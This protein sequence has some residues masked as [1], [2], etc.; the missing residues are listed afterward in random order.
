M[1]SPI[2]A[3]PQKSLQKNDFH[4]K[5]TKEASGIHRQW[6]MDPL[7]SPD[8]I[9]ARQFILSF[10]ES[11]S[12]EQRAT[13]IKDQ[14]VV[15][16]VTYVCAGAHRLSKKT[17]TPWEELRAEEAEAAEDKDE[18]EEEH[19]AIVKAGKASRWQDCTGGKHGNVH[20]FVSSAN[21]ECSIY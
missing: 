11:V 7:D 17:G 4:K 20:L 15:L 12:Q 9:R 2:I 8:D 19:T 13:A 6:I 18:D 14:K 3:N 5:E 21:R 1:Y 10:K 16:R